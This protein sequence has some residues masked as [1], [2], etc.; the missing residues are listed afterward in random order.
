M[1]EVAMELCELGACEQDSF[2]VPFPRDV[3]K[4]PRQFV[5]LSIQLAD[6]FVCG[7]VYID[8]PA[9]FVHEVKAEQ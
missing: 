2:A 4:F 6:V 3:S 5:N 1:K 7:V 8:A 9:L